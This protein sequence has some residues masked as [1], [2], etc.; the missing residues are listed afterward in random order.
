MILRDI[1]MLAANTARTKAYLQKMINENM[2]PAVCIVYTNDLQS[3]ENEAERYETTTSSNKYFDKNIPLLFLLR[4]FRIN[5]VVV[6]DGDINSEEMQKC[7]CKLSQKYI[8]YSGYG[9]QI[10]KRPLFEF[11]KKYLHV[12]AGILP[13]YR[14]STTAYYSLL[15]EDYVGAT[16][17]FL[18]EGIDEGEIITEQTFSVPEDDIDIDYI[19]EPY[20]RSCVLIKAI[21]QLIECGHF[22][23]V[24]QD[25]DS[26]ETYYIIHPVLK[27]L[28]LLK[29]GKSI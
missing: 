14:G 25:N 17:I 13:Y 19:Y 8:I 22:E 9:G 5:Y 21:K 24:K 10:L 2:L 11:G 15:Q 18:S 29:V 23:T 6:E 20:I 16:A 1:A 7:L 12:H 26:A 27:H 28:A 4:S 3:L